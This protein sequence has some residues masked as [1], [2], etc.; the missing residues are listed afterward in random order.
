MKENNN[1]YDNYSF[2]L[3]W[4][5]LDEDLQSAKIDQYLES[6]IEEYAERF[7]NETDRRAWSDDEVIQ[8]VKFRKEAEKAIAARFPIYF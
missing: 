4:N 1:M 6:N 7:A 3:E 2:N 5:E 8:C